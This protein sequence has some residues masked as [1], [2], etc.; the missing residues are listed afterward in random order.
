M[1][2]LFLIASFFALFS[3]DNNSDEFDTI[4]NRYKTHPKSQ[5]LIGFWQLKGIYPP[6]ESSDNQN[7]FIGFNPYLGIKYNEILFLDADYLRF[8]N[9]SSDNDEMYI[10]HSK[11]KFYWFNTASVIKTLQLSEFN[12]D[13]YQQAQEYQF[14]YKFGDTKDTLIV[15]SNGGVFYLLKKISVHYEGYAID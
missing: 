14:P 11:Y 10:H 7:S 6:N 3:C 4:L 15:Q 8:L 1:K 9:Q 2:K 12:S 13:N 5:A